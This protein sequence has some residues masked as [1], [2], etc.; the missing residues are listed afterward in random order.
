MSNESLSDTAS[1]SSVSVDQIYRGNSAAGSGAGSNHPVTRSLSRIQTATSYVKGVHAD[2]EDDNLQTERNLAEAQKTDLG[3]ILTRPDYADAIRIATHQGPLEDELGEYL[4]DDE[5]LLKIVTEKPEA[6]AILAEVKGIQDEEKA[7]HY[8]PPDV[9]YAW[10]VCLAEFLLSVSTWGSVTTFG[11]YISFWL[12]NDT[13]AGADPTNYALSSSLLLFVSMFLTGFSMVTK[14]V[15]GLKATVAVGA[16]LQFLGFML[17]SYSTKLWQLYLT[18]G[19]LMG[20]GF[21]LLFNPAI[22]ILAS[23]FIKYRALSS[24]IVICGGGVGGCIFTLAGQKVISQYNDTHHAM[25]VFG[26]TTLAINVIVFALIRERIPSEKDRSWEGIK[27]HVSVLTRTGPIRHWY[28]LCVTFWFAIGLMG[29]LIMMFSLSSFATFIGLSQTTGAHITA[30]F[31]GCQAIGRPIIGIIGDKCGRINTALSFNL[32]VI[33]LIFA[34]FINCTN[35]VS[36]LIFSIISG[37]LSGWTQVLNQAIMPDCVPL[38]DFPATWTYANMVVGC[39]SL[40]GEV[41]AIK[42]RQ[43]GQPKPFLHAQIF[44]GCMILLSMFCL[45]PVRE[46]KVKRLVKVRLEECQEVENEEKFDAEQ[47]RD[48]NR[49]RIER[50]EQLLSSGHSG[51]FKRLLYPVKV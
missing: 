5:R 27:K 26:Y 12:N 19:V 18:Q 14:Y 46:W 33:I 2:V 21:C 8:P 25:R 15:I 13:Y 49:Q 1:E 37:L 50:Y 51:Y 43:E 6:Q 22:V 16:C 30:I 29:Y 45:I 28:V 4:P 11:I 38:K 31:N 7:K 42:L 41:I 35:F 17:C 23:W 34:F 10:I 3:R 24:G 47:D 39:F 40:C 9:G 36:L 48:L 20:L 32:I 44:A